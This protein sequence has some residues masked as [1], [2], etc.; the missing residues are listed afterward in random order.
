[1]AT[2]TSNVRISHD[3]QGRR[4]LT[5]PEAGITRAELVARAK[6]LAPVLKERARATEDL[7]HIPPETV[8]DLTNAGFFRIMSPKRFGGFELGIDALEEVVLELGRGCGSTAWCQAI[9]GGHSWWSALF[10]E[11]GQEAIFGDDGHVIMA[12]N[13]SGNGRAK[14][15]E[16]GFRLSGNFTYLSGC[17]IANWL[18]IGGAVEEPDGTLTWYYFAIRPQDATIVDN[19]YMLG[20]RG[21]G[22]KNVDVEDLFVPQHLTMARAAVQSQEAPGGRLHDAPIY[23]APMMAFLYIETTGAAVGVAQSAVDVLDEVGR[24][25]HVRARGNAPV[26]NLTLETP[27]MRRHLAEAKSLAD[28]AK[29]LLLHESER[30][31]SDMARLVAAG[32]KMS[33]EEIAEYGLTNARI[34]QLCVEAVDHCFIAAGTSATVIGH[35]MERIFRDMHVMSTHR[36][37]Q[38]DLAT[39]NWATAHYGLPAPQG[40]RSG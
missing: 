19:W 2:S 29:V 36:A 38:I 8:E 11:A 5:H 20:M 7:R 37:L 14:R 24:T 33:R 23:R 31:M 22:S 39:E 27:S 30:L 40:T 13:L 28:T 1:M 15:V 6:A 32:E 3:A 17:D 16:G 18:C 21:T 34:V 10:D 4:V 9:L 26:A 25:K 12:T 35:P